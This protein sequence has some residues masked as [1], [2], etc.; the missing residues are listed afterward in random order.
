MKISK[1]IFVGMAVLALS[2]GLMLTGC[3]TARYVSM[4]TETAQAIFA[5]ASELV[6]GQ[7]G[8]IAAGELLSG[9]G[10]RFPGLAGARVLPIQE[11]FI[12]VIYND[13]SFWIRC[14][15]P[16]LDWDPDAA[17][18]AAVSVRQRPG[19]TT[20]VTSILYVHERVPAESD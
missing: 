20:I 3:A 10:A 8:G 9:L 7:E 2:F 12:T 5:A 16:E 15:M 6:A 13:R 4:E 18:G 11:G 17:G 14:R 19:A 1:R